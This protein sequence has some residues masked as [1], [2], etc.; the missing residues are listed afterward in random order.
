MGGSGSLSTTT[1][2]SRMF[3]TDCSIEVSEADDLG[4]AVCDSGV[5]LLGLSDDFTR[6]PVVTTQT[7]TTWLFRQYISLLMNEVMLYPLES[8][9]IWRGMQRLSTPWRQYPY[10]CAVGNKSGSV[11]ITV[12]TAA[13]ILVYC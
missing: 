10:T 6:Y 11:W 9:F 5:C 4:Q 13:Q 3:A 12:V 2:D 1:T 8:S 7:M